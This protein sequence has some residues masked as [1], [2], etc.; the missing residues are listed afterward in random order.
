MGR[1]AGGV[2]LSPHPL[3]PLP[4]QGEQIPLT[5]TTHLNIVMDVPSPTVAYAPSNNQNHRMP[6]PSPNKGQRREPDQ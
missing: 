1:T 3:D 5:R 2:T 6:Q 4:V